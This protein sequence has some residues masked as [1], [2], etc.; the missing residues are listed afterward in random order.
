MYLMRLGA[1]ARIYVV[2][3]MGLFVC[4]L[5]SL[6]AHPRRYRS[7]SEFRGCSAPVMYRDVQM[8]RERMDAQSGHPGEQKA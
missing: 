1:K 7:D 5:I 6:M 8:P 3:S 2:Q 4:F